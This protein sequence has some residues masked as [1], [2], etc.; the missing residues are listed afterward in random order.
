MREGRQPKKKIEH[1]FSKY[2]SITNRFWALYLVL[3]C[4]FGQNQ[5][6]FSTIEEFISSGDLDTNQMLTQI[7]LKLEL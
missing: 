6:Y 4:N 3:E 5:N 7:N 2:L 1:L